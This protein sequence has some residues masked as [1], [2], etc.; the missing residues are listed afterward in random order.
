MAN[1]L[2]RVTP[3][4]TKKSSQIR[5]TRPSVTAEYNP[6]VLV[7]EKRE[8]KKNRKLIIAVAALVALIVVVGVV[9]VM[10]RGGGASTEA[11]STPPPPAGAEEAAAAAVEPGR[12]TIDAT[13]AGQFRIDGILV[14]TTPKTDLLVDPGVHV[15]RIELDGFVPFETRIRVE[16][17]QEVRLTGIVLDPVRP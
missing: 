14:G 12:L 3:R 1:T 6:H 9:A 7:P 11:S 15:V 5:S 17:G 8:K 4:V 10:L 13:P 16:S 2:C